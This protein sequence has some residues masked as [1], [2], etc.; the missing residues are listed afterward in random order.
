MLHIDTT[1]AQAESASFSPAA[2]F[3][4]QASIDPGALATVTVYGRNDSAASY[5]LITQWKPQ[6]EPMRQVQAYRDMKIAISRNIAGKQARVWSQIDAKDVKLTSGY[7]L[8]VIGTSLCHHNDVATTSFNKI[9]HSSRGWMSWAR[10]YGQGLFTCPVWY[11]ATVYLG[12]EPTG[13]GTTRYFQ[14][15]NAGVFGQTAQQILARKEFLTKYIDCDIVVVDAGTNDYGTDSKELIQ[16]NREELASYFLEQGK[17]VILLPI[18]A[19]NTNVL[20]GGG[21]TRARFNWI[22]QKSRDY[23]RNRKN[24]YFF[25]WNEQWVDAASQYGTPVTGFSADGTHF[26][27]KGGEA[28]GKA[29]A[30]FL[31]TILP[32]GQK[33]VVSPDDKWTA[34]E[35]PRGNILA[36]PMLNG[37]GGTNGTGSTG[38]VAANMLV[39]RVTGTSTVVSSLEAR[40]NRGNW[41]VLTFTLA[42][43]AEDKF[44]FRPSTTDTPHTLTDQDWVQGS[45][46]IETDAY[47]GYVGVSLLCLD[48]ASGGHYSY[49]ME[50]YNSGSANER[51][52]AQARSGI[53]L[54]P[55]FQIKTGSTALKWR[56]EIVLATAVA[57]T[58]VVKIG[59]V[60]L[61][62]V[63]NPKTALNWVA[64]AAA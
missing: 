5:Q 30:D 16:Q 59:A 4:L 39:E 47:A 21:A 31:K 9:A 6:F 15:L 53:L 33:R 8:G 22:N 46:E 14:G 11:D 55:P 3:T 58:P 27:P 41:Q 43:A 62:P 44:Y 60:E 24:C 40:A 36:N 26:L 23:C 1:L 51:W 38:T 17:V 29:F 2:D 12:W 32:A 54:T 56:V 52:A 25:D 57:G 42:G 48:L 28:V 7:R 13:A 50:V 49:G 20:P 45:C 64:P 63:E 35:N 18:L 19:R 37:T 10:F 34:T 61:R